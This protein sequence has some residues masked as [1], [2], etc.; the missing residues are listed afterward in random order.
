MLN[1]KIL[2][3][4]HLFY[5]NQLNFW[6]NKLKNISNCE[7]DLYVT[8]CDEDKIVEKRLKDLKSDVKIVKVKN[9]GYDVYPFLQILKM[10]NL[11]E[12]DYVLKLHTKAKQGVIFKSYEWRRNL[13]EP[14]LGTKKQFEKVLDII[15]SQKDIGLVAS[16]LCFFNYS[17]TVPEESYMLNAMM[18]RLGLNYYPSQY[19]SGTMF[20]AR[21]CIFEK[22]T[23]TNFSEIDFSTNSCTGGNSTNAHVL[24]RI[25]TLLVLNC[26]LKIYPILTLKLK[27]LDYFSRLFSIKFIKLNNKMLLRLRLLKQTCMLPIYSI[28]KTIIGAEAYSN[29]FKLKEL[30]TKRLAIFAAFC[31]DGRITDSQIYFLKGL[32]EVVDNIIFVADSNVFPN[33]IEKIKDLV[34]YADFRRHKGYDFGSYKIG[35]FYAK[36]HGFLDNIQEIILCN[37]SCYGPITSFK[38]SFDRMIEKKVDFWGYTSNSD[39][40]KKQKEHIQTY[41]MVFNKKVFTSEIFEKFLKNIRPQKKIKDVIRK[42]EIPFTNKL[43]QAGFTCATYITNDKEIFEDNVNK[44]FYPLMIIRTLKMPLVKVK[45]FSNAFLSSI[46][47]SSIDTID[48]IEK[49]NPQLADIIR[50]E[51]YL[52]K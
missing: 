37:D 49:I 8:V 24:E 13:I 19:L 51:N 9:L 2:V 29:N 22:I 40:S 6:I 15:D 35:Y 7:W 42:Y 44:T 23:N 10:V 30:N 36:N 18:Y 48:Y 52:Y 26:G 32:Q 50:R 25:F 43:V 28:Q 4:F 45:V 41:F 3:H 12:Y 17:G 21:A 16:S 5:H 20:I 38:D 27:L 46:K 34:C 31:P 1:K 33:E 47:E 39:I 14:L 11:S